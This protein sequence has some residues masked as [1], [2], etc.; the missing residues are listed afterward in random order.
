MQE[1]L[2][3]YNRVLSSLEAPLVVQHTDQKGKHVVATTNIAANTIILEEGPLFC[4]PSVQTLKASESGDISHFCGN[5]LALEHPDTPFQPCPMRC[6][7]YFCGE[8]CPLYHENLH[9]KVVKDVRQHRLYTMGEDEGNWITLET[10]SRAV[11]FIAARID[12]VAKV[13]AVSM[14]QAAPHVMKVWERLQGPPDWAEFPG[15]PL[16]NVY[17]ALRFL[18][19]K[20]IQE[21]LGAE[22]TAELL[23]DVFLFRL[24][25]RLVLNSQA[26]GLGGGMYMLQANFNH[27]CIP[28]CIVEYT[29]NADIAVKVTCDV[30]IG[31]ELCITY[32]PEGLTYE[33]REEKLQPYLF[34]C[35]CPLCVKERPAATE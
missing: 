11:C 3:Y 35:D 2:E 22:M 34:Q 13:N 32:I 33:E 25:G 8:C 14:E 26:C 24:L 4:W 1:D 21:T 27:S 16:Q 28:N 5:C 15:V 30:G 7:E 10:L 17:R 18:L 20:A 9:C 19:N 6:G 23:S 29:P 12:K 31:E